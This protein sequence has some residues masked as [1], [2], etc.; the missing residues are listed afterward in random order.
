MF[1][2]WVA[3]VWGRLRELGACHLDRAHFIHIAF[4]RI[5][6]DR[7][8]GRRSVLIIPFDRDDGCARNG[9]KQ[10]VSMHQRGQ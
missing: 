1:V 2:A 10:P 9:R 4:D 7:A 5:G 8:A 3:S 6:S